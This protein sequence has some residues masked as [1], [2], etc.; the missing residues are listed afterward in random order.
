M[1]S[2]PP[3][4]MYDYV[5][6]LVLFLFCRLMTQMTE[7]YTCFRFSWAQKK[8]L[9]G[10]SRP[11]GEEIHNNLNS[12]KNRWSRSTN[13]FKRRIE[14]E[15]FVISFFSKEYLQRKSHWI[16]LSRNCIDFVSTHANG[17]AK[18]GKTY[19]KLDPLSLWYA[20]ASQ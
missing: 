19:R 10:C 1:P 9:S 3:M 17:R 16:D 8:F 2:H 7:H 13:Y 18:R 5:C 14:S 12:L 20:K 4:Y 6:T 11:E 15:N